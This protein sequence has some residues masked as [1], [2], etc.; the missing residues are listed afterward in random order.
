MARRF[1]AAIAGLVLMAALPAAAA[2][3]REAAPPP[4]APH[5]P[6]TVLVAYHDGV[7]SS[8]IAARE[9]EVGAS[10]VRTLGTGVRV[11]RVPE[12]AVPAAVAALTADPRV[13]FAEPD[14]YL[15]PLAEPNDPGFPYQ[16]AL[17]NTGQEVNGTTGTPDADIDA[18]EAWDLTTGSTEVVVG[19]IDTGIR[20]D[21]ADLA[22]NMWS[23]PGLTIGGRTCGEGTHGYDFV[24]GDCDPYDSNTHGTKV[25]AVAGAVGH[26]GTGGAGVAWTTRLLA[27]RVNSVPVLS[28]ATNSALAQAVDWAVEAREANVNVRVLNISFGGGQ[29]LGTLAMAI[30]RAGEAGILVVVS[31]GNGSQNNDD[32]PTYPCAYDVETLI[33]AGGSDQDD[34]LIYNWGPTTVDLV[35]PANN[36]YTL[37]GYGFGSGTS[38][39]APFVAGTAA[40]IWSREPGLSVAQVKGKILTNVDP[41]P[42]P[43]DRA[44]VATGG[45]LNVRNALTGPTGETSPPP[46]TPTTAPPP[47]GGFGGSGGS[48]APAGTAP[49]NGSS[50]VGG[51]TGGGPEGASAP[52]G[53]PTPGGAPA[54]KGGARGGSTP[55]GPAAARGGGSGS[56]GASSTD[57]SV[58][59]ESLSAY[60]PPPRGG[61]RVAYDVDPSARGDGWPLA[62]GTAL[63]GVAL[64]G[65]GLW[66]RRPSRVEGRVV[67]GLRLTQPV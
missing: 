3:P 14:F 13:H 1:L 52:S 33:C 20:Y 38:G 16:W 10:H 57:P 37:P 7:R 63:A 66:R 8:A 29:G 42:D 5:D 18:V 28:A 67:G 21:N 40:L 23:S 46:T 49:S 41:L 44:K 30:E 54:S 32:D 55:G 43:A 65:V 51:G 6:E 58:A 56:G 62:V 50:G 34:R 48:G 15:F 19:V 60:P 45:R 4:L 36:V 47:G 31:S 26:N 2:R 25:A 22:A 61:V 53:S 59:G 24:E 9:R 17:R 11:L 27:L 35:A 12:G 64:A 39:A